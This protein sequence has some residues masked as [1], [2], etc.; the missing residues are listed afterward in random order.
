MPMIL[1]EAMAAGRPFVGTPVGGVG[2]L[3]EGG[4]LVPVGD[5][6]ALAGAL[7][8]LLA[9]R[10]RA[11]ALGDAGQALCR[12][13]MSPDAVDARLRGLYAEVSAAI[14]A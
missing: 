11:Q 1:S 8:E 2:S 4:V 10:Q 13:L 7:I 6:H 3:G 9:D 5:H 14:A 12:R